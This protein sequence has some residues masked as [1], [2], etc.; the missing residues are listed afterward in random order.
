MY[1]KVPWASESPSQEGQA[2]GKEEAGRGGEY[3][4][5]LGAG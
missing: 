2:G 1:T 4:Q 3:G 5:G